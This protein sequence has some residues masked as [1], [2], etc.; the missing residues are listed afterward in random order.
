[1]LLIMYR[2]G[3]LNKIPSCVS[4]DSPYSRYTMKQDKRLSPVMKAN[5]INLPCFYRLR[6]VN[7]TFTDLHPWAKS[8]ERLKDLISVAFLFSFRSQWFPKASCSVVMC[9]ET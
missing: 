7:F 5:A 1:M 3:R 2:E 6:E 8:V 9:S 4:I